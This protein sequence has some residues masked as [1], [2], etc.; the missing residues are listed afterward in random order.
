[1]AEGKTDTNFADAM[2]YRG[3]DVMLKISNYLPPMREELSDTMLS[4]DTWNREL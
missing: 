4:L 3:A 1:M 2:Y